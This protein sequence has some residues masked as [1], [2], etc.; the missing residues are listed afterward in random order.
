MK[1]I[2]GI[3]GFLLTFSAC[4]IMKGTRTSDFATIDSIKDLEGS[5]LNNASQRSILS[6]FNIRE[7][8]DV[9][10][11]TVV[12]PNEIKLTYY[13]DTSTKQERIFTGE[14][15]RNFFEIYFLSEG[16]T[17]PLIFSNSNTDR[18]RIGKTKDGKLLIRKFVDNSGYLLFLAG[19]FVGEMPHIFPHIRNHKDYIPI[20]ENG[21]WGYVDSLGNIVIPKKFD[22]TT[23]F[24]GDVARVKLNNKWG[25]IN[26]QGEAI[27]P[28]KYDRISRKDTVFYPP[29]F[30]ATIGEKVGILDTDGNEIIPVIYDFIAYSNMSH[31]G[32]FSIRL[33]DKR[34]FASRIQVVVPAIYSR[35]S[36]LN[37]NYAVAERDGQIFIVSRNGYEYESRTRRFSWTTADDR[38]TETRRKIQFHEQNIE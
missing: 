7:F 23:I 32:L 12:S 10:A 35:L 38:K 3:L 19:G 22:F 24:E 26:R 31:H 29:I 28:F 6:N 30:R 11:I 17:I 9:V 5:Y 21:L 2:F 36:M 8:A 13:T 37:K 16:I 18:I 4:G 20:H 25:L 15:K 1:Y 33:G 27:T 14:M 34:G